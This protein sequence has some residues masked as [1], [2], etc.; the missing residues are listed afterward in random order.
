MVGR[1][2]AAMRAVAVVA[3]AG[4]LLAAV[5]CEPQKD[6]EQKGVEQKDVEWKPFTPR[7][8]GWTATFPG[9]PERKTEKEADG[10]VTVDHGVTLA[11]TDAY[12]IVMTTDFPETME[13]P[14]A[15]KIFSAVVAA[16]EDGVE[17]RKYMTVEGHEG[18]ELEILMVQEGVEVTVTN[19]LF[20]VSRRLYQIMAGIRAAEPMPVETQ[21]FID[22]FKLLRPPAPGAP[23]PRE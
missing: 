12:F 2:R 22:S 8:G 17:S 1:H 10:S 14:G 23:A 9:T 11:G 13:F 6:V 5:A 19:R 15:E 7:D 4:L 3:A 18:L 21:R 16:F 20:M